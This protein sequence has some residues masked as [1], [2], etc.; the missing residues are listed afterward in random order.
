VT[1]RQCSDYG[2]PGPLKEMTAALITGVLR[3][4]GTPKGHPQTFLGLLTLAVKGR[5]RER[6]IVPDCQNENLATL[7]N[8]AK[9][10]A[11]KPLKINQLSLSENALKFTY[12][13][14]EFQNF[15]GKTSALSE[16]KWRGGKS[17]RGMKR[18]GD[19]DVEVGRERLKEREWMK[20]RK[21]KE[22]KRE[23]GQGRGIWTPEFPERSTP[24]NGTMHLPAHALLRPITLLSS[25]HIAFDLATHS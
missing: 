11:T 5:E 10:L 19:G 3:L 9:F 7:V 15:L 23:V 16:R 17:G 14:L 8:C 21:R 18:A 2:G 4:Q 6:G 25:V 12:S 22:E 1:G 13:N 24:L 20:R